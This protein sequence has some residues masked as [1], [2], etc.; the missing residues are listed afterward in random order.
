MKRHTPEELKEVTRLNALWLVGADGGVRADLRDANL[1]DADLR[2]ADLRDANLRDADLRDAD[3]RGANLCDANL[4]GANLRGANLCGA[5]L[6]GANLCDA[7]L[8]GADLSGADLSGAN[9]CGAYLCGA[10]GADL[11][12]ATGMHIPP[13]GPF[14]GYKK[15]HSVNGD[16][17][18][19]LLIPAD[20]RR[21]HG[22]ERKCR[23]EF[24]DV[25]EVIGANEGVSD[26]DSSVRYRAGERVTADSWD[27]DRWETC[28]HGI[29][30]MLTKEEAQAYSL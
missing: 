22:A 8:R 13:E 17:L 21:S 12:L 15:C 5:N 2:D 16:I 29:H 23:A 6:R 11:A 19:K 7:N 30:F 27:E 4:C 24:V 25:L 1:R 28:S 26:R 10:K 18:V 3:L 9:L 20:A 14:W